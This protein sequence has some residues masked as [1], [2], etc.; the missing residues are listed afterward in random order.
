[1]PDG[2]SEAIDPHDT[3]GAGGLVADVL[4]ADGPDDVGVDPGSPEPG[5]GALDGGPPPSGAPGA[6]RGGRVGG[7]AVAVVVVAALVVGTA[8]RLWLLDNVPLTA[9]AAIVGLMAHHF[10]AGHANAFYWGQPYGGV[11]SWVVAGA[12]AVA[13]QSS[14]TLTFTPGALSAVAAL[15]VWRIT[16]R[17]V[18]DRRLAVLAG[19]MAWAVPLAAVYQSTTEYGFRQATL[20]CGLA[21][22]LF[23]LRILD[24]RRRY[25]DFVGFGAFAGLAWWSLP[26]SVYL[27]VPAGLVVIGAVATSTMAA[28]AW[29]WVRHLAVAVLGLVVGAS[30][31][32]WANVGS[33]FASLRSSS[34][35]GGTGPQNQG[36]GSRLHTVVASAIPLQLDLRRLLTGAWVVTQPG[37]WHTVVM[38]AIGTLAVVVVVGSVVLCAVRGGRAWAMAAALV[39][40]PFLVALQPGTWYY[41]GGRY[42]LYVGSLLAIA[43]AVAVEE[44]GR[45]LA[46]RG[47]HARGRGT[48]MARLAMALVVAGALVLTVA[49]FHL[50]WNGPFPQYFENWANPNQSAIATADALEADG[51]HYGYADYW[52]AYKLDFLSRERLAITTIAPDPDRWTQLNKAVSRSARPAWLFVPPNQLVAVNG[53]FG[54]AAFLAG[55]GL[56]TEAAFEAKLKAL[57]VAYRVVGAGMVDAVIPARSVTPHDVG[58]K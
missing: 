13:G 51:V 14:W 39:A 24:G 44:L 16:R 36:Y 8:I 41:I 15:V 21:T 56:L 19:A 2:P 7:V 17:M 46:G 5:V 22:L 58:L 57:G 48:T 28:K 38:Y 9:D 18:D 29:F 50:S 33:G 23:G 12:F 20:V 43:L 34:F 11:E 27:L 49:D 30:P 32:L 6:R 1:M 52:I 26:E 53:E 45:R 40:F 3:P 31:W 55:P 54:P 10:L 35:P 42:E 37:T 47:A 25:L 4:V